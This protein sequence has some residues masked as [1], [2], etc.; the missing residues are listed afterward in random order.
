[1]IIGIIMLIDII[2][3]IILL[4]VGLMEDQSTFASYGC[5]GAAILLFVNYCTV[6]W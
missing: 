5:I 1:M 4:A 2:A 3:A 6:V